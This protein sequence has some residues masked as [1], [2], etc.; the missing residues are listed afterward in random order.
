MNIVNLF[1]V[2]ILYEFESKYKASSR[3]IEY[4]TNYDTTNRIGNEISSGSH[5][6]EH[7][8]MKNLKSFLQQSLDKYTKDI[9]RIKQDFYITQT[10]FTKNKANAFH[11]KHSH[12][13]SI[14]SGV[15]YLNA[16]PEMGIIEFHNNSYGLGSNALT[17]QFPFVYDYF[18]W[19]EFNSN[20][21]RFE[22]KT[23]T[24]LIF[25]SWLEHSVTEN[26]TNN[27]RI[28]IGFNSFVR[29]NLGHAENLT[30]ITL[31]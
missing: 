19:N 2:P 3:E 29:G 6:L 4:I 5:V 15:F 1:S 8:D 25:P 13:N 22:V 10:W 20:T 24:L 17:R 28:C 12:P 14:V 31:K 18:D 30:D 9:I 11:G 7:E 21:C 27:T 23:G 26:K 16:S